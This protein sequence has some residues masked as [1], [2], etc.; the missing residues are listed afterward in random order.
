MR[1]SEITRSKLPCEDCGSS[2]ALT[3]Y[4]DG[5]TYCFSCQTHHSGED[6]SYENS[7]INENKKRPAMIPSGDLT[8]T[9][10]KARGIE[11]RT[12]KRY[13]YSTGKHNGQAVQVATYY[14]DLQEP[15]GQ[16]VRTK[17]KDF[18]VLGKTPHVFY[19][20]HLFQGGRRLVITEGEIDCL[21]V[22]QI[23]G[24]KYPAVSLPLGAQSA[25]KVF[26]EQQK[27]LESFDEVVLMFDQDEAGQ[28]AVLDV[29]GLLSP[30]KLKIAKLPLKDPNECLINHQAEAVKQAIWNARPYRP[31]QIVNAKELWD[32]VNTD[33]VIGYPLPW[34]IP[35]SEMLMGIRKGELTLLT[36]GTGV[37]KTTL[38]RELQYH[39]GHTLGLKVGMMMLEESPRKTIQGLMSLHVSKRLHLNRKSVSEE[40]YKKAFEELTGTENFTIYKHFGSLGEE[41]L[42]SAI[43]YLAV[44]EKCDFIFLDHISIAIS[45]LS[46]GDERKLIDRLMTNLR[47]LVEETGV[48]MLII[49]HLTRKSGADQSHEEGGRV[50]L[51][52]LRGSGSLGQL[53][54]NVLAAERNQ[55]GKGKSKS[56]T[57]LRS[58]KCR[59]TGETGIGGYLAFDKTTGRLLPANPK[60]YEEEDSDSD[61]LDSEF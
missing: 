2:D 22:S 56:L 44:V 35:L 54:D 30:N 14:N 29:C 34:E 37:G 8:V 47:S 25:R 18:Y 38:F 51:S 6:S 5:H 9:A 31:E 4:D 10:L 17:N 33:S 48:G 53:A 41:S 16:K 40:S 3:E 7:G 12:C 59:E 24:N 55:Q 42:M 61:G 15:I 52:H 28:K 39:F 11:E 60:D 1:D 32:E 57:L 49:S 19:G 45:G 58:L 21:T 36:A 50:S 13:G 27:W 23:E 26:L 20:Q 43:R 46:D